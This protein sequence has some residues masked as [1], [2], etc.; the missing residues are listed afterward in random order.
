M[1][2]HFC[3][4]HSER[5]AHYRC[6]HCKESICADCRLTM[7]HHYFCSRNCYIKFK[8]QQIGQAIRA[9][10]LWILA[11]MQIVLLLFVV[12]QSFY[13]NN[14][15]NSLETV[16]VAASRPDSAYFSALHSYLGN[17]DAGFQK[18]QFEAPGVQRQ[19][20]YTL[21]LALRKNWAINI[22]ADGKPVISKF[23]NHDEEEQ[24]SLPLK[25]GQN[26]FQMVVLNENQKTVYND[27][28]SVQ[29]QKSQ[30]ELLRHSLNIGSVSN[31]MLALTF[32]GGSDDAH[33]EEILEILRQNNL[34]CTLFLTGKFMEKHPS[35]VREMLKDGHEI[36]NHTFD[37]P[38]LTTYSENYRQDT[39][40]E[41]TRKF[42]QRELLKT[43][44]IFFGISGK[45][46]KPYWRAPYG[47]YNRQILTW[48]AELGYLHVRWTKGFDTYDWITDASSKL[49]RTPAEIYQHIMAEE[50]SRPQGLNGIIVLMHLGSHRDNNHIFETMPK[51]IREI[52]RRGYAL[53]SISDLT[54]Q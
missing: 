21:K 25:Y 18:L 49:Y 44:S 38:H 34:H 52:K 48:A 20:N 36:G 30:V 47:E 31:K 17:Y 32:D 37:H 23:I 54:K 4:N 35:L 7:E 10:K 1:E 51:L 40:P 5:I 39:R 2:I 16:A 45:H 33:T 50:R 53:G 13:F 26:R 43:D 12:G 42:L 27:Q 9:K 14:K 22:W 6:F 11:A 29:Y 41:V 8:T 28:L 24:F 19:N 46:L 3:K 15:L